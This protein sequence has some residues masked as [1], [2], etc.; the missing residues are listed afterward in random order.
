LRQ[1]RL[2]FRASGFLRHTG[3]ELGKGNGSRSERD[4][5]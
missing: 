3:G 5:E 2:D 4:G 1:L